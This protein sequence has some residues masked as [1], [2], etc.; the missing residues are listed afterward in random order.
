MSEENY[1][2]LGWDTETHLIGPGKIVPPIVC[3]QV[4]VDGE[5]QVLGRA[6]DEFNDLLD[7]I[8]DINVDAVRVAHN[9]AFDLGV[10]C[11]YNPKYIK[12]TFELLGE[13]KFA[14]TR[15]RE[16]L[17]N[18]TSHGNLEYMQVGEENRK[19]G[20]S[21]ADLVK[22]YFGID[23]SET[24]AKVVV[25]FE[26]GE[27][28]IVGD[29]DAWR[30][31]Y[32][33]LEDTKVADWPPEAVQYAAEDAVWADAV[34]HE[35]EKV[36]QRIIESAGHDPFETESF[37]ESVDFALGFLAARG[38]KTDPLRVEA[39]EE[40][41]AKELSDDR[42]QGLI[43]AGILRPGTPARPYANGAT[44]E[45][46]TPRMVAAKPASINKK[47]LTNLVEDLCRQDPQNFTLKR[48]APTESNP[49]GNVSVDKEWL[50]NH[51][52]KHP[53]LEEY[54]HRQSLQKLVTTELPRMKWCGQ[55]ASTVHPQFDV[56]KATGRTSSFAS[57]LFPSFN[58]QNVDPRIR[59]GYIPR[60]GHYLFSV[61]YGAMELGTLAQTCLDLFGH[62][63]LA[64]VINSGRDPH[65]YLGAQLAINLDDDFALA[66]GNSI[67][68]FDH[69]A[70]HDYFLG[71]RS[72]TDQEQRAKFKL[73]RTFAKPTG[74]GYPGGL[75]I[76]TFIKFA[77]TTYKIEVDRDTARRLKQI[78]MQT[79]PE[80]EDFFGYINNVAVDDLNGP[81]VLK[82]LVR[83]EETGEISEEVVEIDR[84]RY[85]TPM[86][87]VRMACDYCAACNGLGL[88]S[89]SAE[90]A[91]LALLEVVKASYTPG[92]ELCGEVFPLMFI[93]DEIVGEIRISTPER[94][95]GLLSR[96]GEIMV[97]QMEAVTP[98]VKAKAEP[99]LMSRWD[100]FVDPEHD[101]DGNLVPVDPD[102]N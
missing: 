68:I 84:Y 8:F 44:D 86:G 63:K 50:E 24:K 96:V 60:A 12:Q 47:A 34:Y 49:D 91:K 51:A 74:L 23:L 58:C 41:L 52:H 78:W 98:D 11:A 73:Y 39:I 9:S 80:M 82:T 53:V 90:G 57:K 70:A 97:E 4:A 93:H 22:H 65:A 2:T 31:N 29:E 92:A 72:S 35:Q 101:S 54:Q 37:Q 64:G 99:V 46:G 27:Q 59:R 87:M 3:V 1:P 85:T 48:T 77:K 7:T 56:L 32:E 66:A 14:C 42:L 79:F 19:I 62:S 61:D 95:T 10:C 16:K 25:D 81:K 102:Q 94:Q 43:E 100:K 67:N 69:D 36:R 17:L 76:D 6:D 83:D 38:V 75:G 26:T 40:D 5:A 45:D 28:I 88:Q 15:I 89:P 13:G 18:L 20:Y 33:S 30:L 55:V 21:L 71:L